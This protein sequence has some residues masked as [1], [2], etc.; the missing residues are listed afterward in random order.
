VDDIV[1]PASYDGVPVVVG[2]DRSL[3]LVFAYDPTNCREVARARL[4]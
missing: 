4:P 3:S 2:I 1:G